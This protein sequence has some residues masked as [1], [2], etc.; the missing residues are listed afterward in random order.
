[1]KKIGLFITI[2]MIII[3]AGCS[4]SKKEKEDE[5]KEEDV[6]VEVDDKTVTSDQIIDGIRFKNVSLIVKNG[7]TEFR[8]ILENT[9][10]TVKKIEHLQITFKDQNGNVVKTVNHYDFNNMKKGD[11]KN[12][13]YTFSIDM[14]S[15]KT[16]EYV[17]E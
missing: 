14:S 15:V 4:C 7:K 12:L 5:I 3:A 13:S 17:F 2:L 10:T 8:V 11:T 9:V 1:M 16:I 6:I